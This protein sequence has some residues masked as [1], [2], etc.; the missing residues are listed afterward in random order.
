MDQARAGNDAAAGPL[1]D[2][3]AGGGLPGM[4]GGR[5]QPNRL[6][7]AF[8]NCSP[9]ATNSWLRGSTQGSIIVTFDENQTATFDF[10]GREA[11]V[12][13]LDAGPVT[14][15]VNASGTGMLLNLGTNQISARGEDGVS[16]FDTVRAEFN[17]GNNNAADNGSLTFNYSA[18]GENCLIDVMF[19]ET[20]Q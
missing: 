3:H 6:G 18:A 17:A 13:P 8:R 1:R 16:Q 15:N 11:T 9:T 7:V 10:R 14:L 2:N 5:A 12:M 19:L 20:S 4:R